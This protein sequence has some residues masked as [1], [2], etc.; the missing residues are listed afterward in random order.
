[1]AGARSTAFLRPA[2]LASAA[3]TAWRL[4]RSEGA[5]STRDA[6]ARGVVLT[7]ISGWTA[8]VVGMA[9]NLISV[10]LAAHYL[11]AERYGVWVVASTL[12]GVVT[13]L[14]FGLGNHLTTVL[15]HA[16]ARNDRQAARS[17]VATVFGLS[18]GLAL[19]GLML[20]AAS[21]PLAPWGRLWNVTDPLAA[22]EA[23]HVLWVV[24]VVT[25]V[26]IPVNLVSRIQFAL[27]EGWKVN[28]WQSLGGLATLA[29]LM[30]AVRAH[31]GL[32][33]LAFA[34]AG[35]PVLVMM[36]DLAMVAL[37][38]QR[39]L[40]AKPWAFDR[41]AAPGVLWHSR[42][43]LIN[44]FQSL[45][46][47]AKDILVVNLAYGAAEL[48]RF[49]TIFRGYVV[50]LILIV[51]SVTAAAWPAL[52]DAMA[53]GDWRWVERA[54]ARFFATAVGGYS[55]AVLLLAA[56]ARPLIRLW[57][58]DA[59]VPRTEVAWFLALQF[60]LIACVNMS[61]YLLL[62]AGRYAAV[63]RAGVIG[64]LASLALNAL[65]VRRFG[66]EWVPI[67]NIGCL[68]VFVV[69][70]LHVLARRLIRQGLASTGPAV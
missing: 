59:L 5:L 65:V 63:A 23:P 32:P 46:W 58:G 19:A 27:Q 48:V 31:A 25:L 39:W 50:L 51:G 42:H 64:G 1:M 16:L 49:S 4:A 35:I 24:I 12:I 11:G 62:A 56:F 14:D 17:D 60:A 3:A 41:A 67:T 44:N 52:A 2:E 37:R 61:S 7:V 33:S 40:F 28:L 69:I 18:V 34:L 9:V 22:A 53:R 10:P 30:L 38:E 66:P 57:A 55:A 21:W 8:R 70:P 43:L 36:A 45:F 6:R 54:Y 47:L 15:A 13:L 68:V 20:F 26:S 29:G